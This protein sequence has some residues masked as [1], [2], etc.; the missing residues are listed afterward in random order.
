MTQSVDRFNPLAREVRV[1]FHTAPRKC[2]CSKISS[3]ISEMVSRVS[4][5]SLRSAWTI[6]TTNDFSRKFLNAWRPGS[7]VTDLRTPTGTVYLTADA[8][9]VHTVFNHYRKSSEGP[10][11]DTENTKL[12]IVGI[13]QELYPKEIEDLGLQRAAEMFIFTTS[14]S[15]VARLKEPYNKFIGAA[16][17][18]SHS[19]ALIDIADEILTNL[20]DDEMRECDAAKLSFEFAATVIS[21]LFT[22]VGKSRE[23]HQKIAYALDVFSKRMTGKVLSKPPSAKE[24]EHYNAAKDILVGLTRQCLSDPSPFVQGLIDLGMNDFQL[25]VFI[26]G[27]YFAGTET[28]ASVINYLIWQLGRA[29][30]LKFQE[31]IRDPKNGEKAMEQAVAEAFRLNPPAFIM[32]RCLR[33]STT[34]RVTNMTG[35]ILFR[36]ELRQ[37]HNIVALA[38]AAG[39]DPQLYPD[40]QKFNPHRFKEPQLP[41][42]SFFPF[43]GGYHLCPGRYLARAELMTFPARLLHHYSIRTLSPENPDQRGVLTLRAAPGKMRLTPNRKF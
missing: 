32:G 28:T 18:S 1:S 43:G 9:V 29:E 25:K 17:I 12:L 33:E 7:Y 34:L 10:F 5:Q 11:Y 2:C 38:Q 30:N 27:L 40:P 13:L 42:L 26:F 31:E 37:G 19:D 15:H 23:D 8:S 22:G 24:A 16:A 36:K 6:A 41:N 35:D 3:F 21:R 14:A 39:Q 20:T 4:L